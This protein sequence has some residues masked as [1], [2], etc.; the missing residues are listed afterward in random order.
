MDVEERLAAAAELFKVLGSESRL[1]LIYLIGQQSRTV[2][3]LADVTGLSQPLVSQ[4]LRTLRQAGLVTASR[5]GKEVTYQLADHHVTHVI[6][7]ALAHVYEPASDAA[8]ADDLPLTNDRST[9]DK[10]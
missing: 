4:H 1:G 5:A 2:G 9:N 6:E 10:E 7:D 8:R 3:A